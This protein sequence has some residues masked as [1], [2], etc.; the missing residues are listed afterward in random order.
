MPERER[1]PLSGTWA[2]MNKLNRGYYKPEE[3]SRLSHLRHI[4]VAIPP[5]DPFLWKLN[6]SNLNS[7]K[8]HMLR[9]LSWNHTQYGPGTSHFRNM[10]IA[11]E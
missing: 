7:L 10:H 9:P 11:M 6:M 1:G 3:F 2:V 5:K 4:V 8:K